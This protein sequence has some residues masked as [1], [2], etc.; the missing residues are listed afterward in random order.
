MEQWKTIEKQPNYEV[1][2][3]GRVR[4]IQHNRILIPRIHNQGYH[5]VHLSGGVQEY[6]HR[7]VAEAFIGTIPPGW[8]VNHLD[9]DPANNSL[10]NLEIVTPKQNKQHLH[11]PAWYRTQM[12]IL[13]FEDINPPGLTGSN[14]RL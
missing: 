13:E 5:Q 9:G 3:Y 7:L 2:S 12:T 11:Q 8:E 14:I 4:N 6:I 1:S 10:D